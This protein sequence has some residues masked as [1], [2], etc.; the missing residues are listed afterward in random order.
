VI[1]INDPQ[2]R[3]DVIGMP[4]G[5][6]TAFAAVAAAQRC[7]VSV[8]KTGPTCLQL[9]EQGYDT[10]GFRI[11]GKSCDWG[12]M[13]GFVMR[14]PRLNKSGLQTARYNALEHEESLTDRAKRAGWV[15][16]VTPLKIY[17]E[18]RRW[19]LDRHLIHLVGHG[20]DRWEGN[21]THPTGIDFH[22]SLIRDRNLPGV[23]GVYLDRVKSGRAFQQ[24]RGDAVM[25]Y[26]TK[27]GDH[28]SPVRRPTI[29]TASTVV[30]WGRRRGQAAAIRSRRAS[31][32]S[33]SASAIRCVDHRA[34]SSAT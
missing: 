8:R 32:S 2:F 11:H 6:A 33:P 7:L 18:R 21:A 17:E 20:N 28:T 30:C 25:Q 27:Y 3:R 26:D 34:A 13:A 9:L 14:D 15:A 4:L 19:L 10:K 29:R 16:S 23:W 22:Y 31:A 12:P 1:H 24:I 5:H